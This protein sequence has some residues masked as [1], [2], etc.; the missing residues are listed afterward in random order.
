MK[1]VIIDADEQFVDE[2][3]GMLHEQM[4]EMNRCPKPEIEKI[5]DAEQF[6]MEKLDR[7]EENCIITEI[8]LKETDG[9]AIAR[10]IRAVDE[11]IPIVF[12]SAVNDYAME[13]YDLDAAYYLL[14]PIT[15]EKVKQMLLRVQR[16]LEK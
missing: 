8:L 1:F 10:Q 11:D 15:P 9:L 14:K 4:N 7:E 12:C 2:L 16:R 3:V 6:S 13:C 5:Y